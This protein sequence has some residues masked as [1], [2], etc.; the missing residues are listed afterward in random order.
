ML[1]FLYRFVRLVIDMIKQDCPV[2]R[3]SAL[4]VESKGIVEEEGG[5]E[6]ELSF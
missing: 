6:E 5:E 4:V 2:N 3:A 1:R